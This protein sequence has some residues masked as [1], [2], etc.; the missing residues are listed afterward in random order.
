MAVPQLTEVSW[1]TDDETP[2]AV[3]CPC[4]GVR[5]TDR[6]HVLTDCNCKQQCC[7][8]PVSVVCS[9]LVRYTG[10]SSCRHFCTRTAVLVLTL[11]CRTDSQLSSHVTGVNR[12]MWLN[13]LIPITMRAAAFWSDCNLSNSLPW[14]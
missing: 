2:V 12:V 14:L 5:R 3:T 6:R 10:A 4:F 13:F 7:Q 11:N 9:S 8:S 1:S